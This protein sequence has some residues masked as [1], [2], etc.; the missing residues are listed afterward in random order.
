MYSGRKVTSVLEGPATF[1]IKGRMQ[2][3]GSCEASAAF[4]QNVQCHVSQ[5]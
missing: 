1:Y 5:D 3:V 4:C 2:E